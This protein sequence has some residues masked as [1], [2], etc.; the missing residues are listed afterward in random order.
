MPTALELQMSDTHIFKKYSI[1]ILNPDLPENI[2][3]KGMK[4]ENQIKTN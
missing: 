3:N 2:A 1:V 4:I